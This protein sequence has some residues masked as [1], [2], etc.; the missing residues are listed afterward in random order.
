[1]RCKNN[2]RNKTYL[3]EYSHHQHFVSLFT[4]FISADCN[5]KL[6]PVKILSAFVWLMVPRMRGP[7]CN[8][9][10]TIMSVSNRGISNENADITMF[11]YLLDSSKDFHSITFVHNKISAIT[12][13]HLPVLFQSLLRKAVRHSFLL[14]NKINS[15]SKFSNYVFLRFTEY[16]CN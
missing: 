8:S 11:L 6:L 10:R 16:V 5:Q 12:S 1:M 3:F 13:F 4:L 7:S 14:P 15:F 2:N 9:Y